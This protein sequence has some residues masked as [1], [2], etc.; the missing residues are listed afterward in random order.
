[1]EINK[2]YVMKLHNKVIGNINP[3]ADAAIDNKRFENLKLFI[4]VF[5]EMHTMIDEIHYKWKDTKY[6]SVQ[7]F[8]KTCEEQ[9]NRMGITIEE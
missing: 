2:D 1:M 3:V 6:S 7:P 9:F 8:V 5:D 4:E